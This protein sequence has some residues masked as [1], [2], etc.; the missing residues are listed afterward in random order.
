MSRHRNWDPRTYA[1]V[2]F[3]LVHKGQ[4]VSRIAKATGLTYMQVQHFKDQTT[5]T[6][7][8]QNTRLPTPE[9]IE[10]IRV[11]VEAATAAEEA[12]MVADAH[13]KVEAASE[14]A[15][16]RAA[17]KAE[18]AAELNVEAESEIEG[19]IDL[20]RQ[21]ANQLGMTTRYFLW[22]CLTHPRSL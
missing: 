3:R 6:T 14:R 4:S 2:Y 22:R 11:E 18:V 15:R 13:K 21:A 16:A 12:A 7:A 17:Q 19:C 20:V 9:I 5:E 8:P 1:E 10:E